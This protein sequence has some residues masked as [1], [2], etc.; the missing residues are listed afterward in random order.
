M[1]F[2]I[3]HSTGFAKKAII[4]YDE[5][6]L[7]TPSLMSIDNS[8][9]LPHWIIGDYNHSL[10]LNYPPPSFSPTFNSF[11]TEENTNLSFIANFPMQRGIDDNI[12]L[13]QIQQIQQSLAELHHKDFSKSVVLLQPTYSNKV[14]EKVLKI[15][16]DNEIQY[17]AFANMLALLRN[18]R[19]LMQFIG[20]I[21]TTLTLTPH[22]LL[23]SPFSHQLFPLLAY[24]G[25]DVFSTGFATLA[26]AQKIFLLDDGAIP[27]QEKV[28][29]LC[30]CPACR[31]VEKLKDYHKTIAEVGLGNSITPHL[32][33]E[34]TLLEMHNVLILTKIIQNIR[35]ALSSGSLRNYVEQK[36]TQKVLAAAM[37]RLL[38]STWKQEL[39]VRTSPWNDALL[40]AITSLSFNR[41]AIIAFQEKIKKNYSFLP[42]KKIIVL[43]PC[44]ARKPY[45]FSHS[46]KRF[47]QA[48][49]SVSPLKEPYIQELIL[50]SPL[51]V[52]PRELEMV[53]PAAHYDIP[54][55]GDWSH[56]ELTIAANQLIT[57]LNTSS[58]DKLKIIAHVGSAY[59]PICKMVEEELQLS[60]TYTSQDHSPTSRQSLI[61]LEESLYTYTNDLSPIHNYPTEM[62][63]VQLLAD[64]QFGQGVGEKLFPVTCELQGN[65]PH[66]L[67]IVKNGE[68]MGVIH[69]R[70]GRFNLSLASGELLAEIGK[71]TVTFEG[72]SL[73]GSTL[74]GIGVAEAD[75]SIRPNDPVVI[76]TKDKTV[77][78]VGKALVAGVD[79]IHPNSGPVVDLKHKE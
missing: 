5:F 69:P 54:V 63:K 3:L 15:I 10:T 61:K 27:L 70:T 35:Y 22:F 46:H 78:A 65:S 20:E 75:P 17:I 48:L 29:H 36:A 74:F 57:V 21:R 16:Q 34:S 8:Q 1:S 71:H 4:A 40:P 24:L 38:D 19:L 72:K 53:Y 55:T 47:K 41:P 9:P 66:P 13:S 59:M 28:K 7:E 56:E 60:F 64:Y 26:A 31:N 77:L 73:K 79:M 49:A 44:S 25:I 30:F 18:Y 12:L 42:S 51:G 6:Q 14:L 2:E 67:R 33:E 39:L 11:L 37:L 45:S 62:L 58:L 50:T 52:V 32:S 23:L 43:L 76:I 68:H